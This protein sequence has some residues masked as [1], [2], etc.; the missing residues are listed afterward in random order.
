MNAEEVTM[1]TIP[2][3]EDTSPIGSPSPADERGGQRTRQIFTQG[4]ARGSTVCTA[5]VS[6]E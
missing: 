2:A 5:D 4:S 6:P 1:E 3:I